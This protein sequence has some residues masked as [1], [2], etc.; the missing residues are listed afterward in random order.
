LKR[1]ATCRSGLAIT[2]LLAVSGCETAGFALI[3]SDAPKVTRTSDIRFR[4]GPRGTL[5]I[6]APAGNPSGKASP[7]LVFWYGG[8]WQFGSKADYRFVGAAFA[9]RGIVTAVPDYR[10]YP[11]VV[12]P[13]FL[14]DAAQSVARAQAEAPGHGADPRCTV[15]GGHSAGAY[16]AVMLAL[17]PGYLRDAGVDPATICGYFGLAGP[18][19]IE[20]N[21]PAL[22]AIF[23]ARAPRTEFQP[24]AFANRLAPPGLLIH[25]EADHTVNAAHSQRLAAALRAQGAV[26]TLRTV[27]GRAHI[28]VAL[29]LSRPGAFRI[30]GLADSIATF[31]KELPAR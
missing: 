3:N 16:I 17:Q 21:T 30:P 11:E 26:V 25:G 28:D 5:D 1:H 27:P 31:V 13:D 14:R 20:P 6:Y 9:T 29:A 22:K 19:T 24:I 15:L 10:V 8:A 23:T 18:Y 7:L 4:D 2:L 12:F